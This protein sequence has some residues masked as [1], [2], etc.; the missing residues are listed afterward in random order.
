MAMLGLATV[1]ATVAFPVAASAAPP[2]Q[3]SGVVQSGGTTTTRPLAGVTV[4]LLEATTAAPRALGQATTDARGRFTIRAAQDSSAGILYLSAEIARDVV[5]V[6]VLGPSLPAAATVNELTTVGAGFALAQFVRDGS[7]SGDPFA[8]RLAAGMN[9]AVV[10]VTT[11]ASS[12]VLLSSPNADE[13]ISLRMTRSLANLLAACVEDRSATAAFLA[14]T[15]EARGR[16][17]VST[18]QALANLARDPARNAKQ[19]DRLTRSRRAYLPALERVPDN[20][21]VAV[22]V[23]DTGDDDNLFGGPGNLAFDDDGYAWVTNNV[24]QGYTYS[25]KF[26]PVL[27]PNGQPADGA[28]GTPI[29]PLSGS[30]ILGTGFGVTLDAVGNVWFGNFGWG[31]DLPPTGTSIS[32]FSPDGSPLS[33]SG[34]GG[35]VYQVQGMA[36]DADGNVWVTGFGS[37]SVVVFP[38]GDVTAPVTFLEYFGSQPFDVAIGPDGAAW[39]SNSGGLAGIYPSSVARFTFE[40]GILRRTFLSFVGKSL[41][42]LDVD[43]QGIAWVAS[44]DD[45]GVFGIRPDGTVLGGPFR[46][47]GITGPWDVTVDGEDNLWVTNFGP[48]EANNTLSEGR[49]SKLCGIRTQACPPGTTKT[50]DP[51]TPASGY[52]MPSAGSQVLLHDGTP[53][54]GNNAPPSFV[55]MM[56]QTASVIDRA[57]NIWTINNW[58]PNFD[59]DASINP[60]GDGI[61]IFLGLAPPTRRTPSR[62]GGMEPT[63]R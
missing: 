57:G 34:E 22:K 63:F 41:K 49:L 52:T 27:K 38:G 3:L 60:G 30:G 21:S 53:L 14:A 8:L 45:N 37:D 2:A 29:S 9:D 61:V 31:G 55:P 19:I 11:G 59:V 47:G 5:L 12:P 35:E 40:G 15:T 51:I 46:D 13:T 62:P 7:V 17:P 6:A 1:A 28:G 16:P 44:L 43:S 50:G 56:R 10:T 48:T 36:T 25:S 26:V 54:Y 20:W 24:V 4:T 42:G 32:R 23:N 33:G 58:K 18:F 39:V